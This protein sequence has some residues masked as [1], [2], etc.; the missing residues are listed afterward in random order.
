MK[1]INAMTSK[2]TKFYG[3]QKSSIEY[4][5]ILLSL[6]HEV[7]FIVHNVESIK[8]YLEH[9][10]NLHLIQIKKR[11]LGFIKEWLFLQKIKPDVVLIHNHFSFHRYASMGTGSSLFMIPHGLT[12]SHIPKHCF[13]F[14]HIICFSQ[15][16]KEHLKKAGIPT[17]Y[18]HIV[19]HAIYKRREK[20]E[21]SSFLTIGYLGRIDS[22]KNVAI[23]V[24]A[25]SLLQQENISF[26]AI[27]AGEG[28][29]VEKIALLIKNLNLTDHVRMIGYTSNPDI[30]FF[31]KID[32]FCTLSCN[33]SFGLTV[34]EAFSSKKPCLLGDIATFRSFSNNEKNALLCP[35][36]DVEIAAK[37][38]R[39]LI[40][41][42]LLR[43]QL[44]KNGFDYYKK[45][46]TPEHVGRQLEK[47]L[48]QNI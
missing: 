32:L 26:Q 47:I 39:Q 13:S 21:K 25:L 12:E 31:E 14:K 40:A 3:V 2:K 37:K 30:D 41:D 5:R 27:I 43:S 29:D 4:V 8:P 18:L 33:E 11:P 6:G 1:I 48:Q 44:K 10:P 7:F 9:H 22:A 46:Y 38:L 17:N 20:K 28:P 42:P 36:F 19:P 24:R 45:H 15:F 34:I 16:Q 35:S 23:F